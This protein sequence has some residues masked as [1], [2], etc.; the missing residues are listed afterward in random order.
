VRALDVSERMLD[1]AREH[2]GSLANVEWLLG[3]GA[4][5]AGVET[6]SA[7]ACVSHVVFQHVPDPNITLAY[8]REMGRVLRPGAWAAFQI[9]NDPDIHRP[10]R[11]L[12]RLRDALKA[13]AGRAPKGQGDPAWRGSAVELDALRAA[14][15]DGGM[16][17]ERVE[18]AGT[19]YCLAL[20]RR[21]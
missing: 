15:A 1:L 7:D 8:V 9:S 14:A 5:L 20:T 11:G 6:A 21:D 16:T 17:V 12:G 4:S 3:D 18:G 13:A 19:Q 10:R 2:N